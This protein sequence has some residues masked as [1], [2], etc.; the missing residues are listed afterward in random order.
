MTAPTPTDSGG[1]MPRYFAYQ[2]CGSDSYMANPPN[3]PAEVYK[4]VAFQVDDSLTAHILSLRGNEVSIIPAS[5]YTRLLAIE[6]AARNA[7]DNA[8]TVYGPMC[9]DRDCDIHEWNHCRVLD[10]KD[11]DELEEALKCP[12]K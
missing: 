9:N 11:A 7:M 12:M 1:R 10:P 4:P 3:A 8:W 6:A 5:T 2:E